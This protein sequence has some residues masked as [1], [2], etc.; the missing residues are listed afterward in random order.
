MAHWLIITYGCSTTQAPNQPSNKTSPI[1][2]QKKNWIITKNLVLLL[3][4]RPKNGKI[5]NIKIEP[6]IANTPP[7]LSGIALKIA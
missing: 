4:K 3:L 6:N 7:N 1:K 2:N 5:N